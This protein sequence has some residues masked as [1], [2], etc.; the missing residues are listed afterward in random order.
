M[1]KKTK[2]IPIELRNDLV[3]VCT[4]ARKAAID[5]EI[6]GD[7]ESLA[8]GNNLHRVVDRVMGHAGVPQHL[9]GK[10]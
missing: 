2:H 3:C 7:E 10:K 6:T 1:K 4:Y 9:D 8:L 5:Y